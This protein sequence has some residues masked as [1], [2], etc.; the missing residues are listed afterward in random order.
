MVKKLLIGA[1][2]VVFMAS[3][4]FADNWANG[5]GQLLIKAGTN[6]SISGGS[7]LSFG[8][9]LGD[10]MILLGTLEQW[11]TGSINVD[12][13]LIGLTVLSDE[14]IKKIHSGVYLTVGGG[15]GKTDTSKI[16]FG[17]LTDAGLFFNASSKCR[18]YL[19]GI[20]SN[21]SDVTVYA[22]KFTVSINASFK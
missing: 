15:I 21:V 4:A 17:T 3:M 1:V 9:E 7:Y 18:L 5:G 10:R 16:D 20:C 12:N 19:G 6:H 14:L 13:G 2:L 8:A 22:V 11:K